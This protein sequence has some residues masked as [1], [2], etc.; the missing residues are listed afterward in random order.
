[1]LSLLASAGNGPVNNILAIT[2]HTITRAGVSG[3]PKPSG[4][5]PSP[6]PSRVRLDGSK[7]DRLAAKAAN[8]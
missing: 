3:F 2:H 4:P 1:V 7:K 5:R 6:P 8:A